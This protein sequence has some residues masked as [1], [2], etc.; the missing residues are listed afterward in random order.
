MKS[1]RDRVVWI[2]GASRGIGAATAR[3]FARQGARVALTARSQKGL[4]RVA[5]E[6]RQEGRGQV[7]VFPADV[8]QADEVRQ[9]VNGV[10][11]AWERL[12]VVVANAGVYV[13]VPV[14]TTRM[15]DFQRAFAVNFYGAVF[16]VL[17]SLPYLLNQGEGHIVLVTSMDAKT[18]IPPDGP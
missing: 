14:R 2:T 5:E 17:E 13:Q 8:T 9:A 7:L 18:G 12:D 3:L 1:L 6:I 16:A 11:K 10:L 15:E 4:E